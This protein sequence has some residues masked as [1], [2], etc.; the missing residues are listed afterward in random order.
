[1]TTI[2]AEIYLEKQLYADALLS[3]ID[4]ATELEVSFG[5]GADGI[6][7]WA[8]SSDG[9]SVMAR[10]GYAFDDN[11][12]QTLRNCVLTGARAKLHAFEHK[13]AA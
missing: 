11:T 10:A 8:R 3:A 5:S 12:P 6:F 13:Q 7:E 4:D 9:K 2:K 1:M